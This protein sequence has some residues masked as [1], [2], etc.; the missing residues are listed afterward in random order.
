[1]HTLCLAREFSMHIVGDSAPMRDAANQTSSNSTALGIPEP[2]LGDD[3]DEP[4]LRA[5][6]LVILSVQM[7]FTNSFSTVGSIKSYE[8]LFLTGTLLTQEL[9]HNYHL[10]RGLLRCTFKVDIQKAYDTVDWDF[11]KRVLIGFGFH[12][13]M[14]N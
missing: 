9:M 2:L 3:Q 11:L 1:M 8:D 13:H 12:S 10:D 5:E 4:C 14:I 6:R 7:I